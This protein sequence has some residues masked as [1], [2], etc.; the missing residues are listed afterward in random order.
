MIR[1]RI[2]GFVRLSTNRNRPKT[3]RRVL[4][5]C[6]RCNNNSAKGVRTIRVNVN[7]L[8]QFEQTCYRCGKQCNPNAKKGTGEL[9][10]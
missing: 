3:R 4:F 7:T 8:G 2:A 5:L 1:Q 9:Y 10:A 6:N